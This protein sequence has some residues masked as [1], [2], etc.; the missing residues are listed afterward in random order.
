MATL[1]RDQVKVKSLWAAHYADVPT[2]KSAGQITM[3]E[4]EKICAFYAGGYLYSDPSK[5]NPVI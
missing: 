5:L 1:W 3:L 4:E 2:T